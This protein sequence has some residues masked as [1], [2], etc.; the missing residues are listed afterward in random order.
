MRTARKLTLNACVAPLFLAVA[1]VVAAGVAVVV[2]AVV[3]GDLTGRGAA[4]RVRL[5]RRVDDAA[6]LPDAAGAIAV[7]EAEPDVA[8]AALPRSA[9]PCFCNNRYSD[10]SPIPN[11]SRMSAVD[12]VASR[13]RRTTSSCSL[14]VNL[15]RRPGRLPLG[16]AAAAT[17]PVGRTLESG[18]ST[19]CISQPYT[20]LIHFRIAKRKCASREPARVEHPYRQPRSVTRRY[21]RF[22][23]RFSA[24]LLSLVHQH[25]GSGI[26][27]LGF[28]G[29]E[30]QRRDG[31][32]QGHDRGHPVTTTPR[33]GRSGAAA[34][35]LSAVVIS[36]APTF[37][38][39]A[40][41]TAAPPELWD[42]GRP[43]RRCRYQQAQQA[44]RHTERHR[45]SSGSP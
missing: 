5:G 45:E 40:P 39:T 31:R 38:W 24:A 32:R 10:E 43:C 22:G 33:Y 16:L 37:R 21:P 23:T 30:E 18:F 19:E 34:G 3:A 36:S 8:V 2:A 15:G 1:L 13:Y 17:A 7:P 14:G 20:R 27:V 28:P 4:A 11:R 9:T 42:V 12:V 29:R 25:R 41:A 44:D 26:A 6:V 35:R